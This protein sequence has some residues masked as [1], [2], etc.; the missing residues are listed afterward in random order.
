[1]K[2]FVKEH[3]D[4]M[5]KWFRA[6]TPGCTTSISGQEGFHGVLHKVI[7]YLG[8]LCHYVRQMV[9]TVLPYVTTRFVYGDL[10]SNTKRDADI[11]KD[12]NFVLRA[13]RAGRT[14][15]LDDGRLL[16]HQK[17]EFVTSEMATWFLQV[18]TYV[19]EGN[20]SSRPYDEWYCFTE[21]QSASAECCTCPLFWHYGKCG[22]IR[23]AAAEDTITA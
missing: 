1:M 12:E 8:S 15:R 14:F 19:A 20:A 7:R 10:R 5:G 18:E 3:V 9:S 16:Y 11:K 4:N 13:H 21:L 6:A 17:D 2:W 22:G 23:E